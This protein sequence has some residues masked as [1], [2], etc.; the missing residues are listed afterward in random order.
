MH[1]SVAAFFIAKGLDIL[2]YGSQTPETT[3]PNWESAIHTDS[4]LQ[5]VK[6]AGANWSHHISAASLGKPEASKILKLLEWPSDALLKV[7]IKLGKEN[8]ALGDLQG[9]WIHLFAVHGHSHLLSIA[10]KKAGNEVIQAQDV[11]KRTPLHLAALHAHSSV[12]KHLLKSGAKTD[13]RAVN[14]NTALNFALLQ[15]HQSVLK[16][17]IERDPTLISN[18]NDLSQTLLFLGA[19]RGSSSAIKLLLERG[20]D[21][22]A[23][24]NY[25]QIQHLKAATGAAGGY[26]L[27]S[28]MDEHHSES[29]TINNYTYIDYNNVDHQ[30]AA[31]DTDHQF[32]D[33]ES[34]A[35]ESE[36]SDEV[37]DSEHSDNDND[38]EDTND[39]DEAIS[40]RE[41]ELT[42][43]EHSYGH[44]SSD[45][46]E[47]TEMNESEEDDHEISDSEEDEG[48]VQDDSDENGAMD[49]DAGSDDEQHEVMQGQY[50]NQGHF[51][52]Q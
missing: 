12:V 11:Q 35:E 47:D 30:P 16:P 33:L 37:S 50:Q 8:P 51:Q 18:V 20:A 26:L 21:S 3:E 41:L 24:D 28:H 36:H 45:D 42:D 52:E 13:S 1:G 4:T 38:S 19:I 44:I 7:L 15:G 23:L 43:S 27:S 49:S 6:Y 46:T 40:Y 34:P 48:N 9:A 14:G 22:R 10:V 5:L 25:G 2:S 32:S 39:E 29:N 31:Y 17:L